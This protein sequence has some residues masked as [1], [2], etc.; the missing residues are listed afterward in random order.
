PLPYTTLF[1]STFPAIATMYYEPASIEFGAKWRYADTRALFLEIDYQAWSKFEA[2]TLIILDPETATCAPSC[3]V[4]FS[5]GRNLIP[6]TR[7]VF[8]P[9]IGHSWTIGEAALR[10]GYVFRPGI[11]SHDPVGAGNAIDPDEHRFAAG[12]GWTFDSLF[13]FDA[14]GRVDLH[15]AYSVYP[16]KRITKS[17]GDEN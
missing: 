13:V 3:G 7:D 5:T 9:K 2:P 4:D 16:K 12:Y 8:V 17:P 11:Y 10:F 1:R 6:K 14:P 15:A